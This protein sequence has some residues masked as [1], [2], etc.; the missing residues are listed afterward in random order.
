MA[1]SDAPK[2]ATPIGTLSGAD[3]VGTL[4]EVEFLASDSTACFVGDFVKLTG[5]TGTDGTTPVAAQAA[6]GD[7]VVGAIVSFL[8][9]FANESFDS[10]YRTA[11]TSRKALVAM[12]KDV[13]YAMQ[14]DSVG[15]SI[16]A[17]A[18]GSNA[19]VIVGSGSTVTGLSGMEIDS[20]SVTTSTA[21][22]RIH[23]IQNVPG[24]ALGDY[25]D[26]VVSINEN[27]D[28]NGAGY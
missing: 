28:D 10:I 6:A 20:S 5:T 14:E 15:G 21:Q 7:S 13:L 25:A 18:A 1:N 4:R 8:P 11:S 22:L 24:N 27:Q 17:T 2:G 9:D 16:A 26:W 12:G 23:H 19:D 3:W